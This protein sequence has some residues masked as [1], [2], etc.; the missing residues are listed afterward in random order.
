MV[1]PLID[2]SSLQQ[3]DLERNLFC[4]NE[5]VSKLTESYDAFVA[6]GNKEQAK[7]Y[8]SLL[9]EAHRLNDSFYKEFENRMNKGF[10]L[11][12]H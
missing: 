3:N 11:C 1:K 8:A 2:F 9:E 6:Q 5:A 10:F 7:Y 12:K 4:A